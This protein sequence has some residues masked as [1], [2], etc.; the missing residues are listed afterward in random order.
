MN[1]DRS[2]EERFDRALREWAARPPRRSSAEAAQ[3]VA[4]TVATRHARRRLVVKLAAAAA[5]VL[6]VGTVVAVRG[7]HPRRVVHQAG[8]VLTAP[9]L[10]EGQ[11]LIWLDHETPLY[12]TF[13]APGNGAR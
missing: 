3:A 4:A 10:S 13:A 8:V 5:C 11:V 12:M 6:A 1:E 9:A 7:F 2:Q